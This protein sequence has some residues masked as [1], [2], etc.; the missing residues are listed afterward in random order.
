MTKGMIDEVVAG[1]A[2]A[3]LRAKQAGL[4]GVEVHGAHTYLVC[5]FLSPLTNLRTDEYGGPLENRVRFAREVLAAIRAAVG[6]DFVLGIRIASEAVEGG[7][8]PDEVGQIRQLLEDEQLIDYVNVSVGGYY[9]FSKMI[10][11]MHEPHGY[12]LATSE[13]VTRGRGVPAIVTGRVLSLAEA[14]EILANGIADIVS[15]V[16]ALIADPDLVHKSLE[17]REQEVR[18]C[19]GCN[20]G[21]VGRRFAVGSAVGQTGCTVNPAAGY[22]YQQ[23]PLAPAAEPRTVL[24][25]GAGPAGLEAARTAALR[26]HNVVVHERAD[27]PGG[28]LEIQRAAPFRNEIANITDWLWR[29]LQRLDAGLFLESPVDADV[30]KRINPDAVILATGSLPRRDGVQRMRPAHRV[31]GIH[32]PHVVTPLEVL[33]GGLEIPRRAVVFDDLGNYQ[34]V[35]SAEWLLDRGA[36]VLYATSFAEFC[37]DLFRSFQRDA[38][39]A[40]LQGYP[41]FSLE[42]RSSV[43]SISPDRAVLR[44]IDGGRETTVEADLVVLVTGFDPQTDLFEQLRATGVDARVTGDAIAPLLLPHAIASGRA[45]GAAV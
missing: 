39:A 25:V 15:M 6:H 3:A 16:R 35:G 13:P 31:P 45:A 30:V 32:L 8:E 4:D 28:L 17:G 5:S 23:E 2:A 34:A 22:E 12:E 9:A 24:V 42:T 40:R 43:E 38:T 19:I 1:F 26:G 20:E 27:Q 14:E 21:C 29:E 18:P 37:P 11:A 7:L 41:G 10:G 36:E 33:T 44:G